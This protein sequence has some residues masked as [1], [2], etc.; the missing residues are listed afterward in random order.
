MSNAE[1]GDGGDPDGGVGRIKFNSKGDVL[2]YKMVLQGTRM[3]CGSG[4]TPWSTYISCE[5]FR[6]GE[7]RPAGTSYFKIIHRQFGYLCYLYLYSL[8][9]IIPSNTI[10]T[11]QCWEVH[12]EDKWQPR[13][14]K[15]GGSDGGKF[16]SAAFDSRNMR[17]LKGFITTDSKDGPVLR[18]TPN[19]V[20]LESAL[21]SNDFSEL[22][23]TDGF[24][25]YLV[26]NNIR[27]KLL[28]GAP[29]SQKESSQLCGTI[30]ILKELMLMRADYILSRKNRES[31]LF[32]I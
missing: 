6:G 23:H 25:E 4:Y 29:I 32:W 7:N 19:P 17:K 31:C 26:V 24:V 8:I 16:E 2:E 30:R 3:N 15:M 11:G 27:L 9:I 13:P 21:D 10:S 22:L 5:E 28:S 1:I 20:A 12:P 14:T 18:F